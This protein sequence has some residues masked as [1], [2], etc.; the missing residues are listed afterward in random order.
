MLLTVCYSPC[1]KH[2]RLR[3]VAHADRLCKH[4]LHLY[5]HVVTS[6]YYY[7]HMYTTLQPL[8]QSFWVEF[9]LL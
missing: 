2:M 4:T 7:V 9:L 3:V 5:S 6:A 8:L 1:G